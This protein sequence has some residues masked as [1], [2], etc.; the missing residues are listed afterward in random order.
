MIPN[1]SRQSISLKEKQKKKIEKKSKQE[2]ERRRQKPDEIAR[3]FKRNMKMIIVLWHQIHDGH[4][5]CW[6]Q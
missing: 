3:R 5:Q 1:L 6:R 4:A 2:L